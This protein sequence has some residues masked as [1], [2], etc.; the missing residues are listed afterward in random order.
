MV[1]L[2]RGCMV[3]VDI[4]TFC[5][6]CAILGVAIYAIAG[7]GYFSI[8]LNLNTIYISMAIGA[9]LILVSCLGC[10]ASQKGHKGLLCCY[11]CIV[12]AALAA[13]IAATVLIA[14]FAGQISF[15]GG[16]V[17]GA[18]TAEVDRTLNNAILSTYVGCCIGCPPSQNCTNQLTFFNQTLPECS[19]NNVLICEPVQNC[20]GDP[21]QDACFINSN[22]VIPT[23]QPDQ[24]LCNT[25]KSLKNS[26]GTPIV[27]NANEGGCGGGSPERYLNSFVDYFNGIFY[28]FIVAF[29]ILCGIQ[30]LNLMAAIF[31]LLCVDD[32]RK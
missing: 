8:V 10:I 12:T 32:T 31:L 2:A 23:I 15:Q 28:W 21:D 25:F 27:G 18:I 16:A 11:L 17:S 26:T 6:G 3:C 30:A 22:G 19:L 5:L 14:R 4:I 9:V 7:Y 24:G 20:I 1:E 13:Q 29:G